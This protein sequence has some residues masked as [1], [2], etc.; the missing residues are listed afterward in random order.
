MTTLQQIESAPESYPVLS[1]AVPDEVWQRIEQW[2][3]YRFTPRSVVWTV[4]GCGEWVPPLKPAVISQVEVW[5]SAGEWEV[6]TPPAAPLG[7]YWLSATGP[8]RFTATVGGG[9][10][11][12]TV[13]AIV[14]QAAQRLATYMASKAGTAGVRSE[15][16]QAGSISIQRSRDASWQAQAMTNSGAADLLRNYRR[17]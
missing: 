8:Y 1:P 14:A 13:P 17:V 5:S 3:A 10:P 4:E 7:G 12:P 2:I 11:L 16:I 6:C 9:S 15:R